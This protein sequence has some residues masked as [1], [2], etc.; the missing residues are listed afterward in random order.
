M[1][2][3]AG[4]FTICVCFLVIALVGLMLRNNAVH[5]T[6][7]EALQVMSNISRNQILMSDFTWEWR[8]EQFD[9]LSYDKMMWQFWKRPSSFYEGMT[10]LKPDADPE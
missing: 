10:C 7:T 6:R 1:D 2:L 3:L 9:T 4:L 5:E 8:Y